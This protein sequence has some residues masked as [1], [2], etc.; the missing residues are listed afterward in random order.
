MKR[1]IFT[2]TKSISI[3][4]EPTHEDIA[5]LAHTLYENEG[6]SEGRHLQYWFNAESMIEANFGYGDGHREHD[7]TEEPAIG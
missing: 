1:S 6:R 4:Q 7:F 2:K 3:G 5:R